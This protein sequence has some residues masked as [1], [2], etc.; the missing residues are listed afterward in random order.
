M[1]APSVL[2]VI[3]AILVMAFGAPCIHAQI[4][5]I[6]VNNG[7]GASPSD[8]SPISTS[9]P[10]AYLGTNFNT[11]PDPRIGS[12]GLPV[13]ALGYV[14][15]NCVPDKS[16]DLEAFGYDPTTASL[17]Y[18]GGFNPATTNEGYSLGD[19]FVSPELVTQPGSLSQSTDYSNP[20]Y[21]YA[22]HFITTGGPTIDYDIY[23]L[24]SATQLQ[25]VAFDQN[26]D[27]DPYALDLNN[28][29]GATIIGTGMA[30]VELMTGAGV[31][32]LLNETGL[33]GTTALFNTPTDQTSDDNYVLSLNIS[34]MNL[35]GSS[36]NASLTEQCGNDAIAGAY[37]ASNTFQAV[38][39]PISSSYGIMG[40]LFLCGAGLLRRKLVA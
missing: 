4:Q 37:V 7:Q 18:V 29:G 8:Y 14:N 19:I 10:Y 28:L 3:F 24:T 12:N 26:L 9:N 6:T 13:M 32:S 2:T 36:F 25:T 38:P 39:E 17:T 33:N 21:T 40:V 15:A 5:D 11:N 31:N 20:G 35:A 30:T 16:W 22:I 34:S 23:Q 27:S 1:K